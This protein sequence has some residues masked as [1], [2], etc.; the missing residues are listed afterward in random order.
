MQTPS[1]ANV[2]LLHYM[3]TLYQKSV[4]H[5]HCHSDTLFQHF[6]FGCTVIIQLHGFFTCTNAAIYIYILLFYS[7]MYV[8]VCVYV[9]TCVS[10][11]GAMVFRSKM[12]IGCACACIKCLTVLLAYYTDLKY[13]GM[14]ITCYCTQSLTLCADIW[15]L[16]KVA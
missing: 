3:D 2:I 13:N 11:I 4:S 6:N 1:P 12:Y 10:R 9:C 16:Y 5:L 7:C 14:D 8:C 15:I